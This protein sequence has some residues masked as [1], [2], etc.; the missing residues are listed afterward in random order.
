MWGF[1]VLKVSTA[2]TT[3]CAAQFQMHYKYPSSCVP[4]ISYKKYAYI[5]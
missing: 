5:F 2:F 1:F 4:S 3:A